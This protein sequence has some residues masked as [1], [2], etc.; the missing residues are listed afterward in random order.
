MWLPS[1]ANDTRATMKQRDR[2]KGRNESLGKE[3][4]VL[5]PDEASTLAITPPM[6]F[7]SW[8]S[9]DATMKQRDRCKKGITIKGDWCFGF[10]WTLWYDC[11]YVGAPGFVFFVIV[12]VGKR[13][14]RV[15]LHWR[16]RGELWKYLFK[17]CY[18]GWI[19]TVFVSLSHN[20]YLR[21]FIISSS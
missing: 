20:R 19:C 1:W 5:D 14:G 3:T 11:S 9:T 8:T 13:E 18:I 16:S 10:R 7:P 12:C 2:C 4:D 21:G 15:T 6:Q 17:I